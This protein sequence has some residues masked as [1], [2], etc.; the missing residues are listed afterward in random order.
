M[1]WFDSRA[2]V[3]ASTFRRKVARA[4]SGTCR[5]VPRSADRSIPRE[6]ASLGNDQTT[7]RCCGHDSVAARLTRPA[8]PDRARCVRRSAGPT[9]LGEGTAG[10]RLFQFWNERGPCPRG[11]VLGMSKRFL[12]H[13]QRAV[14]IAP[15]TLL[16]DRAS[17]KTPAPGRH[18][19]SHS[20]ES[21][22][23]PRTPR[24]AKR[25]RYAH[26]SAHLVNTV[27]QPFDTAAVHDAPF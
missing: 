9:A 11:L 15:G 16:P 17:F 5:L 8:V 7:P 6:R 14:S 10:T 23:E 19:P 18:S 13:E 24:V 12:F 27:N 25:H 4:R 3:P 20:R 1:A 26:R 2:Y 21:L 22:A